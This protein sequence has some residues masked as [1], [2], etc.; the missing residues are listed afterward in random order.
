MSNSR[1][2]DG[3]AAISSDDHSP[4]PITSRKNE[5]IKN[6]IKGL[7]IVYKECLKNHAASLG[8]NARDGCGEFM[9]TVTDEN[10]LN[11][12]ACGCH[13]NFH[14]REVDVSG[15]GGGELGYGYLPHYPYYR[16]TSSTPVIHQ[17]MIQCPESKG[18]L[19]AGCGTHA[20]VRPV[21]TFPKTEKM[22]ENEGGTKLKIEEI[23]IKKKR[24]RTRFT[25]EQKEKMLGFAEKAEW[26]I[27]KLDQGIV[28]EFCQEVGIK[29]RVLKVW[30]H[31]NKQHFVKKDSITNSTFIDHIRDS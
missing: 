31:N 2:E 10:N 11:C 5:E 6:N 26:K 18:L 28:Q 4:T 14:R 7:S 19:G 1:N 22:E 17:D 3:G 29:R 12:S 21:T 25:T 13:R 30:M 23:N 27:Q 16:S 8:G 15:G 9:L 20:L 24:P